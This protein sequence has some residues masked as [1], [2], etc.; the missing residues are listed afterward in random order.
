ME[1]SLVGVKIKM[2]ISKTTIIF[3][4]MTDFVALKQSVVHV[5]SLD[6]GDLQ[7]S[8]RPANISET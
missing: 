2:M 5:C 6:E 1:H 8:Q 4:F 7:T 3:G